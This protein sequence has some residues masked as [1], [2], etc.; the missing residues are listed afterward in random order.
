[1]KGVKRLA[2]LAALTVAGWTASSEA[3]VI[4]PK[5]YMFYTAGTGAAF[6][7][8]TTFHMYFA[9][10]RSYKNAWAPANIQWANWVKGVYGGTSHFVPMPA[11]WKIAKEY[12]S[13]GGWNS[14]KNPY[15]PEP[16]SLAFLGTGALLLARRKRQA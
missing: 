9:S 2:I 10:W 12:K 3:A 16:T 6:H 7:H 8:S 5:P 4:L 15:V 11:P 1:M 14:P 13:T